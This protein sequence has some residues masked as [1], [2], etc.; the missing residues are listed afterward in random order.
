MGIAMLVILAEEQRAAL[1]HEIHNLRISFE[2]VLAGKVL[3]LRSKPAGIINRTID[4][5]TIPLAN[6]KVVVT[7]ARRARYAAGNGLGGSVPV[8]VC[9]QPVPALEVACLSRASFTSSSVSASASPPR[10]TCSPTISNDGRS[11]HAWRHSKRSSFDPRKRAS[12]VG[13][14]G[15]PLTSRS[16]RSHLVLTASSNSPARM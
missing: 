5:Q 8:T 10:V 7:M 16:P 11:S 13:A 3:D 14:I 4:L 15:S 2:D 1:A 6:D 9:T 12:T